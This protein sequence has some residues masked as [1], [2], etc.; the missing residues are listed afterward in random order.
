MAE[1]P[2]DGQPKNGH[3]PRLAQVLRVVVEM[4]MTPEGTQTVL[5]GNGP[6]EACI[7]ALTQGIVAAARIGWEKK[8]EPLIKAATMAPP[9]LRRLP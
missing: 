1:T 6:P 3:D 9:A 7:N 2:A 5:N 4:R 8:D